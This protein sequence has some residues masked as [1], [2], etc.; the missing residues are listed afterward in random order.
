MGS[1]AMAGHEGMGHQSVA[2]LHSVFGSLRFA[3][4]VPSDP[5][6]PSQICN[7]VLQCE[8]QE[9]QQLAQPRRLVN[10]AQAPLEPRYAVRIM[11]IMVGDGMESEMG[12]DQN[13]SAGGVFSGPPQ[14]ELPDYEE[15]LEQR[16]PR[17]KQ[18]RSTI[19]E[20]MV[21]KI[22]RKK[23]RMEMVSGMNRVMYMVPSE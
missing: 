8:P 1:K 12:D 20:Q 21:L 2:S 22:W 13:L 3:G 14:I 4:G 6:S 18:P 9:L 17:K 11:P 7:M 23:G 16:N 10:G 5:P 15:D 19:P